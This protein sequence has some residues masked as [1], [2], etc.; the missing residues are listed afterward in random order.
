MKV[1]GKVM[2]VA[3][4]TMLGT[5]IIFSVP[6]YS[7][8]QDITKE[9]V[10]EF[11]EKAKNICNEMNV[12]ALKAIYWSEYK[13]ISASDPR[14]YDYSK[15]MLIVAVAWM[16]MKEYKYDY[17]LEDLSIEGNKA[18]VVLSI[19]DVMVFKSGESEKFTYRQKEMIEKRDGVLKY[20]LTEDL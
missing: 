1:I 7:E 18:T 10:S 9:E 11:L 6:S 8:S 3:F 14:V 5:A 19:T 4:V 13:R 16:G 15:Y 17:L 12:E 20:I 2:L